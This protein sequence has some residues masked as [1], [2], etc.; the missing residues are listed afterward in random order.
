MPEMTEFPPGFASWVEL[1]SPDLEAS[2]HFYCELFGWYTYT[3]T[4]DSVGEYEVF[5]LGDI[6]GPEIGG[7]YE[8]A[9]N[10]QRS[11]WTIYFRTD[12]IPATLD[13]VRDAGGRVLVEPMDIADLGRMAQCS[14][15]Q[16]AYFALWTAYNLKGAGVV[17]EP[18]AMCWVELACPDIDEAR[19]FYGQVFGWKSVDRSYYAP[20]YVNWKVGNWS[21]AGMVPLEEWWPAGFPSHWTPYFWV[22][23]CDA[24]AA[25]AADL[26]ARIHVPPT[27]I[28]PG[29]FSVM[30]DPAGARLAVITPAIAD[31]KSVK[32]RP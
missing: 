4:A 2:K 28:Q 23:D 16:G 30:T 29:R 25:R 21:V 9:D 26:G 32:M 31:M 13:A 17:D 20:T 14:D 1:A 5:T 6:Q 18:S 3:L 15:S 11:S 10:S 22:S 7:M 24:V 12:D 19:R 27:D 8:L